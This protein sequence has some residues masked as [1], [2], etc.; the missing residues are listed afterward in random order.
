MT[1][2]SPFQFFLLKMW[3]SL[4]SLFF[5][6]P[7]KA[8]PPKCVWV[9]AFHGTHTNEGRVGMRLLQVFLWGREHQ[10]LVIWKAKCR[11]C[12]HML[13][14]EWLIQEKINKEWI[15]LLCCIV[16]IFTSPSDT[17][18][19]LFVLILCL[20]CIPETQEPGLLLRDTCSVG[21]RTFLT[22]QTTVSTALRQVRETATLAPTFLTRT[23]QLLCFQ[24]GKILNE[25]AKTCQHM[26]NT[27]TRCFA[28]DLNHL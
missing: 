11:Y 7:L 16:F 13:E 24:G 18:V 4:P 19:L 12:K 1:S 23:W 15:K 9:R 17:V 22:T 2:N 25:N 8:M 26:F 21:C 10:K 20:C 5:P 3:I 27:Y 6:S 28:T 14:Y